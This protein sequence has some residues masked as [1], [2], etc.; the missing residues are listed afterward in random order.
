MPVWRQVIPSPIRRWIR[1][2]FDRRFCQEGQGVRRLGSTCVWA[3]IESRLTSGAT[4]L[5]G[6]AGRDISFE[7]ELAGRLGCRVALFD[8]SPTGREMMANLPQLPDTLRFFPLGLAGRS[9]R[10]SFAL[11]SDPNEG[12]FRV[13][14]P[15]QSVSGIE[16]ECLGPRDSMLRAAMDSL[17]LLKLDIEGFEYDFIDAMLRANI[18]PAQIAVEF[19]HFMPGISMMKTLAVTRQLLRAGYQ[20][21]HKDQCDY[22][23]VHRSALGA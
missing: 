19:H 3:V 16:F 6:G 18:R 5:A 21:L 15:A 9:S 11:P 2:G 12:S 22:L 7:L 13:A 8:P 23:F 17:E 20:I 14:T 10:V 4:V 1:R